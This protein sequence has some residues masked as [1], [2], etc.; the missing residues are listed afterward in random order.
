MCT[1][2]LSRRPPRC[3]HGVGFAFDDNWSTLKLYHR[4]NIKRIRMNLKQP[5]D[6]N[7]S[8]VRVVAC[9]YNDIVESEI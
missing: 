5:S 3:F 9:Q 1:Y 6:I 4:I 2:L 7:F 8:Y